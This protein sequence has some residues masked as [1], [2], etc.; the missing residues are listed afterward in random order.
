MDDMRSFLVSL[1]ISGCSFLA[2]LNTGEQLSPKAERYQ[3][4]LDV[5]LDVAR[6]S[7]NRL[8]TNLKESHD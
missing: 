7:I 3:Q 2:G 5:C 8:E 1:V 4:V 6:N